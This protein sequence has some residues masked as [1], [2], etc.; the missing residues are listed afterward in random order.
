MSWIDDLN[1]ELEQQRNSFREAQETG[2]ATR[3]IKANNMSNRNKSEQARK[4][5]S[6]GLKDRIA[7]GKIDVVA[8]G[9]KVHQNRLESGYYESDAHQEA[10]KKRVVSTEKTKQESG[11]YESDA[12][13]K[14][15]KNNGKITGEKQAQEKLAKE[16]RLVKGFPKYEFT[17]F[18]FLTYMLELGHS[19]SA[20]DRT[21]R[22]ENLIEKIHQGTNQNNPSIFR[23]IV[24]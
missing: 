3:R 15:V 19:R 1:K 21:L 7:S 2:E 10:I 17:R 9:K 24:K 20:C 11:Y 13:K 23:K 8:N 12:F 5:A 4:T 6:K 14:H 16:E 22:N 18:E